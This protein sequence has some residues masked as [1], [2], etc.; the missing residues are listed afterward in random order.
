M[1][2]VTTRATKGAPL[3]ATEH[4]GNLE[5]VINLHKSATAPSPTYACMLWVDTATSLIKQRNTADDAWVTLGTVDAVFA[6]VPTKDEDSMA[7]DSA[8][9]LATQQSIKAYVDAHDHSGDANI[10]K[11]D[12]DQSWSGSQRGTPSTVTDGTLD[13][14][15]ANNFKYTPSGADDLE[16]SNEEAGQSGFITVINPSGYV[17]GTGS[18]I[19]KGSSWDVSTAGTY[20]VSYYCDGTNVYVSASEALS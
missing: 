9:H 10:A 17:V 8:S 7:S 19:K 20:I 12:T 16:F 2:G 18:E 11:L 3:S 14:D 1:A 5:T 4:D 15:T 13:L 6:F